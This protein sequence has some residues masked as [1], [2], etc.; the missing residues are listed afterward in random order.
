MRIAISMGRAG[1]RWLLARNACT[2]TTV[3]LNESTFR[4]TRSRFDL[5]TICAPSDQSDDAF[6]FKR[7]GASMYSYRL[8]KLDSNWSDPNLR[9]A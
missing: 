3:V 4:L 8:S 9:R 1:Y 5:I 6:Y 2:R 7:A